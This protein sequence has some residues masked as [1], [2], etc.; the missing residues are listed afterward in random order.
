MLRTL[1]AALS[2]GEREVIRIEAARLR[3]MKGKAQRAK[4]K[5]QRAKSEVR[6]TRPEQR[7][8]IRGR[9]SVRLCR[10]AWPR[11]PSP[12]GRGSGFTA[13]RDENPPATST[14]RGLPARGPRPAGGTDT[15]LRTHTPALS[16][17][18]R[19][20]LIAAWFDKVTHT[21]NAGR[22]E[23]GIGRAFLYYLKSSRQNVGV[24]RTCLNTNYCRGPLSKT[25]RAKKPKRKCVQRLN[26]REVKVNEN[27]PDTSADDTDCR[28][29][30]QLFAGTQELKHSHR[31]GRAACPA[32]F[33]CPLPMLKPT[34]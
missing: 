6:R 5:A 33:Y 23:R 14:P 2:Q 4:S 12:S 22:G 1:T 7:S 20:G 18:E 9:R 15:M 16:Q 31:S 28:S 13:P 10:G 8:E 11:I 24:I 27:Q 30:R 21:R 19:E 26:L 3:A 25:L 17:G 29:Q 32:S 34:S